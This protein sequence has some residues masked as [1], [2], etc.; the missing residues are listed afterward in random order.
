VVARRGG[1]W[2]I[3]AVLC[4]LA[5]AV[6]ALLLADA[7]DLNRDADGFDLERNGND[8]ALFLRDTVVVLK[9]TEL[10]LTLGAL[11]VGLL[12]FLVVLPGRRGWSP[13]HLAAD[14]RIVRRDGSRVGIGR[15]LVR[16]LGWVVDVLPG[17][18][19]VAYLTTRLTRR[20]QRIGDVL[21]GTFVV[22]K[23]ADG[24]PVDERLDGDERP[25]MAASPVDD[26]PTPM[27]EPASVDERPEA[28]PALDPVLAAE[29][30]AITEAAPR[31]APEPDGANAP[32]GVPP[33][34]PIWDRRNKRYVLWHS[35]AE[36]WLTHTDAGWAPFEGSEGDDAT[37]P[38]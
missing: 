3:D 7:Y 11:A 31:P 32:D 25:T 34:Q 9:M 38:G 19:V 37:P 1:A 26:E 27:T 18:P 5:G 14:L 12:L 29:S 4:A 21:A 20:H 6:P 33:D 15:A 10:Y 24:R 8:I 23:R 16:T 28:Q 36:R 35:K 30:A 13:G 17:L 2:F 22:D